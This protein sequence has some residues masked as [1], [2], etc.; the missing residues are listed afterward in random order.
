M[1]SECTTTCLYDSFH[2]AY[3]RISVGKSLVPVWFYLHLKD[4][5][6]LTTTAIPLDMKY[7]AN[8]VQ[9]HSQ[10]CKQLQETDKR[11]FKKT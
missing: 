11:L 7:M 2:G 1:D 8:V 5:V 6:D 4:Q 9:V 3:Q 10:Y